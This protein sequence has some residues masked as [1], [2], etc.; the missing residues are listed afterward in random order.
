MVW[1]ATKKTT[2]TK[3]ALPRHEPS[4]VRNTLACKALTTDLYVLQ[5][6]TTT[7]VAGSIRR[8]NITAIARLQAHLSLKPI[9]RAKGQFVLTWLL[10][11]N[12]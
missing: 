9:R 10:A 1:L 8:R 5:F 6:Y 2:C 7:P 4:P 11:P 12:L 3:A